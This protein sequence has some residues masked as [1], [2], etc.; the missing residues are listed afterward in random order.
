M[1]GWMVMSVGVRGSMAVT[2]PSSP[3]WTAVVARIPRGVNV[4]SSSSSFFFPPH[5]VIREVV[6]PRVDDLHA[7]V[8]IEGQGV[9]LV[10]FVKKRRDGAEREVRDAVVRVHEGSDVA[11]PW[12]RRGLRHF[13]FVVAAA[14][15]DARE[16]GRRR[17]RKGEAGDGL[18]RVVRGDEE[19]EER[20]DAGAEGVAA[21]DELLVVEKDL[22]R[23]ASEDAPRG[24]EHAGMGVAALEVDGPRREVRG[25]VVDGARAAHDEDVSGNDEVRR[26]ARLVFDDDV[27][28][29]AGEAPGR[30]RDVTFLGPRPGLPGLAV[31]RRRR[32]HAESRAEHSSVRRRRQRH[33]VRDFRRR[34][35][36][37]RRGLPFLTTL[38]HQ[39]AEVDEQRILEKKRLLLLLLVH[40]LEQ[41][42]P[43]LGNFLQ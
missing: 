1:R 23:G 3:R 37:K 7:S 18:G 19:S 36:S 4:S 12:K 14:D 2:V 9:D 10:D 21:E 40:R 15:A 42:V 27:R 5:Q 43:G 38:A 29:D 25:G 20:R 35:S 41:K 24:V 30:R 22:G 31:L 13:G 26:K 16:V 11:V 8:E 28:L 32:L 6:P 39:E 17:G 34:V 33:V